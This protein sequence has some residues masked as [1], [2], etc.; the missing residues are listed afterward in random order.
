[1]P[2]IS[3]NAV[4]VNVSPYRETSCIL[5]LFSPEYG[6]ITGIAKGIKK[7][8]SRHDPLERGFNVNLT[9]YFRQNRDINTV[10]DIHIVDFYPGIRS[11]LHKTA[12]RDIAFELILT[13]I[14][15][16]NPQNELYPVLLDFL[17]ELEQVSKKQPLYF[18]LWRFFYSF[19]TISGFGPNFSECVYCGKPINENGY[20]IIGNGGVSCQM[21]CK[22]EFRNSDLLVP[23]QLPGILLSPAFEHD[24]DLGF[25]SHDLTR[26]TRLI[27]S[28][29][30][31]HLDIHREFKSLSFLEQL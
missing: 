27:L 30:R 16:S 11:S 18:L 6:L 31:Y 15:N 13:S 3:T 23:E 17:F 12:V 21:C 5:K 4:I 29:C 28:Y 22:N 25:N 7:L 10:T 24:L 1:M 14:I 9:V 26:L 2:I 20:L 19:A 8:K